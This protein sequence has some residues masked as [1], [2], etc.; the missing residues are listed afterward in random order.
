MSPPVIEVASFQDILNVIDSKKAQF[1]QASLFQFMQDSS[2]SPLQR[3]GF[4]PCIAHFI[5]SFGDLNKYVFRDESSTDLIQS[6]IDKHTYEDDHHWHWF[7][8]DLQILGF[9]CSQSFVDT[10]RSLWSNETCITRQLSYRLSA[11]TLNA[12]PIVK[13]AAI[14]AVEA[15]GNILF[16]YTTQVAQELESITKQEYIYF[17]KFHLAVETGHAVKDDDAE[18]QLGAITLSAEMKQQ[19]LDVVERV[20]D[21]FAAW[22]DEMLTYAKLH[23]V[24]NRLFP[25]ANSEMSAIKPI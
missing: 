11:Y 9:D 14:E 18:V 17:G 8:R 21:L 22:L 16:G 10:L 1:A 24:Q 12:E 15:T 20:F 13:L 23:P 7:L 5:M 19:A 3:L 4:A 2:I 25:T 6:A